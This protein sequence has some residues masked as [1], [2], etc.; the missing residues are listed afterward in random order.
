ML[1]K[2]IDSNHSTF[3]NL[4]R[5]IAALLVLAGHL[6]GAFFDTYANLNIADQNIINPLC[7]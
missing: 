2:K 5:A 4:C 1:N 3:L 6:R 7:I